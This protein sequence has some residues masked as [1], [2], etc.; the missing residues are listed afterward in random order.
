MAVIAV[1]TAWWKRNQLGEADF[2]FSDG[3]WFSYIS[4]TTVGLGDIFLEPQ[5]IL[6]R[7]LFIFPLSFLFGFVFV[8]A[9][10]GKFAES[11]T[12]C[13]GRLTLVEA[14]VGRFSDSGLVGEIPRLVVAMAKMLVR[15]VTRCCPKQSGCGRKARQFAVVSSPEQDVRHATSDPIVP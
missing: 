15:A 1:I 6:F 4:I 13:S 9:F 10:L 5:V 7:D 11:L 8:A 12:G 3:Y 2:Q 14:L